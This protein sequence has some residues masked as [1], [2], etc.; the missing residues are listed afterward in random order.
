MSSDRLNRE[1]ELILYDGAVMRGTGKVEKS[2]SIAIHNGSITAIGPNKD[3]LQQAGR[4]TR[5]VALN[6]RLAVPGF[7]D[8]HFHFHEWALKRKDM[9]L[10]GLKSLDELLAKVAEKASASSPGQWIFGQGWNETDWDTPQIPT[11]EL[12]DRVSPENPVLLWRCDLHLAAANSRALELAGIEPETPNPPDGIIEQDKQGNLTGI[13]RELAINLIRTA[14][15]TP[16]SRQIYAAYREGIKALHQLGITSVHDVR[17][18]DDTDGATALNTFSRLEEEGKLGLRCWT[19]LPGH[20]LDNIIG[21]GLRTGLGSDNLR[22]GHIKYFA[23]G[24]VGA[25]TAWMM[26]PYQDADS[27]MELVDMKTLAEEIRKADRAGLSVMV[28]AIGDRANR[29][30]IDIFHTLE[31]TR[32]NHSARP[33]YP[34]RIEHVQVIQPTDLERLRKL[35]LALNVTPA[36]MILDINLIDTALAERGVWAYGFRQLFDTGLPVMFSSDCPVCTPDPLV[37]IHAAVTRQRQDGTPDG[38]WYPGAKVRTVEAVAAYTSIPAAVHRAKDL[39]RLEPGSK[40]DIAVLSDNIFECPEHAISDSRVE[41]TL[42][43]GS[44]VYQRD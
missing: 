30:V 5:T 41:M 20:Q 31:K 32:E 43:N 6:G 35:P 14:A 24:G 18:M 33:R 25:R 3:I 8:T 17:L 7:M 39:G 15:G 16:D 2:C 1:P 36:N 38:G 13:L 42:F 21:L 12:L 37:G 19:T 26:E 40:A 29:E 28:H 11:R 44:I 27:G 34:H 22:I 9:N 10:E 23:D 4:K